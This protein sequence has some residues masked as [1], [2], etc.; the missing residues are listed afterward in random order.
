[1]DDDLYF[2]RYF[3]KYSSVVLEKLTRP[4]SNKVLQKMLSIKKTNFM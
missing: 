2:L 3:L 4:T 1:M